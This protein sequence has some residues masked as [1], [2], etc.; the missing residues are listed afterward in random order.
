M[1]NTQQRH[2][3]LTEYKPQ[4]Q[5]CKHSHIGTSWVARAHYAVNIS[6]Y[7]EKDDSGQVCDDEGGA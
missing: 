7:K 6:G 1:C 3:S 2:F 5:G 4:L